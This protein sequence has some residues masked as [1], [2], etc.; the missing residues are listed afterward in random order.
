M[1]DSSSWESFRSETGDTTFIVHGLTTPTVLDSLWVGQSL[2][3]DV[4]L[5]ENGAEE[6]RSRDDYID[7]VLGRDLLSQFDLEFDMKTGRLRIYPTVVP[8]QVVRRIP[9]G[10]RSTDCVAGVPIRLRADVDSALT[11][12]D[13]DGA[14]EDARRVIGER[15]TD[16]VNLEVPL[17][18]SGHR[19]A[20]MFDSGAN[21]TIMNWAAARV[22]GL[23]P[24]SANVH[25]GSEAFHAD[26]IAY[27]VDGV[28]LA[29]GARRLA[30]SAP[31][32]I[33]DGWFGVGG[34]VEPR[35]NLGLDAFRGLVLFLSYSTNTICV[36]AP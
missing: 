10:L 21:E 33:D 15:A 3:R 4:W 20:S 26:S 18:A 16:L 2:Q 27:S 32:V 1:R 14:I 29:I 36:G 6:Y 35:I 9:P 13:S 34:A 8:G 19:I 31:L 25:R 17:T 28:V 23:T 12:G 11:R 5:S 7:G 22:F 24:T 30:M